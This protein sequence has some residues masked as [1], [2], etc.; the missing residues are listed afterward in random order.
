M[1]ARDPEKDIVRP[2]VDGT[3]NVLSAAARAGVE[4]VLY[5]STGG[6]ISIRTYALHGAEP[7]QFRSQFC[8]RFP[9]TSRAL[10]RL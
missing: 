5:V 10:Q 9:P 4:K 6:T 7:L 1:W 3:R 2:S 8:D